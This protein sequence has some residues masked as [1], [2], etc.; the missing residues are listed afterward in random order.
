MA[1]SEHEQR[2]LAELEKQLMTEEPR[3]AQTMSAPAPAEPLT[4]RELVLA[5]LGALVGLGAILAGVTLK[6]LPLGVAGFIALSLA[7]YFVFGGQERTRKRTTAT[8]AG[9]R[10]A[11]RSLTTAQDQ[12]RP[13]W[14][15]GR[16]RP[17]RPENGSS[18][19]SSFMKRLE[20]R[21]DER[22]QR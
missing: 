19:R 3:L 18:S 7:L 21:W 14:G 6:S 11:V 13:A 20:D 10:G 12:V 22:G 1:L 2:V 8:P 16:A 5:G 4:V 15:R 17:A 9:S